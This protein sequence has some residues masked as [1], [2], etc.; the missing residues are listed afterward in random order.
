V[1]Q[2]AASWP[3]RRSE[4]HEYAQRTAPG[5]GAHYGRGRRR[6]GLL[7]RRTPSRT[8]AATCGGQRR[9]PPWSRG[10]GRRVTAMDSGRSRVSPPA[11]EGLYQQFRLA[12]ARFEDRASAE[13]YE[14]W[15]GPPRRRRS[16]TSTTSA[17]GPKTLQL[18]RRDRNAHSIFN[19]VF[20]QVL[21]RTRKDS[22]T[23]RDRALPSCE[24]GAS[25]ADGCA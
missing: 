7:G 10:P 17:T 21:S 3:R 16:R 6:S 22:G 9:R 24:N 5:L 18:P 14:R 25:V 23:E 4:G 2:S 1:D 8:M 15:L 13:P 19:H 11:C 12:L 20:T